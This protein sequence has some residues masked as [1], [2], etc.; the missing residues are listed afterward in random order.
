MWWWA[1]SRLIYDKHKLGDNGPVAI[2]SEQGKG[3]R[4]KKIQT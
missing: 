1:S 4:L 3:Y 2:D